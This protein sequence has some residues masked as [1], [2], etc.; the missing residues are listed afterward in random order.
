M[1]RTVLDVVP[2][3]LATNRTELGS[4]GREGRRLL[5]RSTSI[6]LQRIAE[7]APPD[8]AQPRSNGGAG[9]GVIRLIANDGSGRRPEGRPQ[10]RSLDRFGLRRGP[11]RFTAAEEPPQAGQTLSFQTIL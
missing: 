1:V 2:I 4:L 3:E 6:L 5:L 9:A 10:R 8:G 7:E 11:H